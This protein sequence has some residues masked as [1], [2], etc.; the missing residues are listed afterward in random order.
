MR[1]PKPDLAA[2]RRPAAG[3]LEG[4]NCSLVPS[5]QRNSSANVGALIVRI[6]FGGIL[7]ENYNKAPPRPYSDY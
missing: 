4:A 5:G 3:V 7:Y 2:P 6:G 1:G